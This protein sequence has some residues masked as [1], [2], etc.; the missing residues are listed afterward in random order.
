MT[1][2]ALCIFLSLML[3]VAAAACL[4]QSAR[5][6]AAPGGPS[7]ALDGLVPQGALLYIEAKDF[8][9]LLRDWNNS[10]E[11]RQWL[12]S[13]NHSVFSQSLLFLRL[14]RFFKRF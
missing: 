1:K 3:S 7:P 11:K 10:P 5:E 9:G 12:E 2:R 4:Y 6:T 8:A 14:E 13:D